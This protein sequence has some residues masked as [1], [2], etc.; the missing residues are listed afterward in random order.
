M[1]M[2]ICL[3]GCQSSPKGTNTKS[4][5]D[6]SLAQA[7]L[8]R[9]SASDDGVY[10]MSQ[11]DSDKWMLNYFDNKETK[12]FPL[13]NKINCKHDND[14][15]DAV[16]LGFYKQQTNQL[17]SIGYQNNILYLSY[18]DQNTHDLTI[19]SADP[20]GTN[21]KK[22]LFIKS[23]AKMDQNILQILIYDNAL[24]IGKSVQV[25]DEKKEEK[26]YY[27]FSEYALEDGKE[28]I[29]FNK[30]K[31]KNVFPFLNEL[32]KG[33][34]Y[35]S[36]TDPTVEN[37]K[38][39]IYTKKGDKV[40]QLDIDSA[41]LPS[42]FSYMEDNKIYVLNQ[43]TLAVESFDVNTNKKQEVFKLDKDELTLDHP[44]KKVSMYLY[45]G[46][47]EITVVDQEKQTMTYQQFYDLRTASYILEESDTTLHKVSR[48][49]DK[50]LMSDKDGFVL[51]DGNK[52]VTTLK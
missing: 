24:Y 8:L 13:C 34:M 1:C 16:Q 6:L 5:K 10:I 32:N 45:D 42:Q 7:Y 44:A 17:F 35:F 51:V 48:S 9:E 29:L 47:L 26:V 27:Q 28:K 40:E 41:K 31:K 39:K 36:I 14:E 46:I 38:A 37:L 22:L 18:V 21:R 4:G 25:L 30:E 43:E 15:C 3:V 33:T 23:A 50:Y 20:D 19:M 2:I 49:G 12:V 52:K 11:L